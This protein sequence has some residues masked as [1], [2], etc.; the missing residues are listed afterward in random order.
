MLR[1]LLLF[2]FQFFLSEPLC[3]K[4]DKN[5][6]LRNPFSKLCLQSN[7]EVY[8]PDKKGGCEKFKYS[9]LGKNYCNECDEDKKIC[10]KCDEGYFPDENGG[11]SY[12]N[13]CAVSYKGICLECKENYF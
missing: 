11:C 7:T 1:Y 13:N 5:C 2:V 8:I 9:I 3:K 4:G 6:I 10:K 12:S